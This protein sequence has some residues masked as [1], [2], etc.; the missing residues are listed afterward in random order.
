M[1]K[2][3]VFF[4]IP[5]RALGK[6]DVEFLVKSNGAGLRQDSQTCQNRG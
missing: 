5:Q 3:D 1:A 4:T 6:A 2:H